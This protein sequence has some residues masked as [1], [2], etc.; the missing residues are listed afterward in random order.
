MMALYREK[1]LVEYAKRHG[2]TAEQL[3][4]R[5]LVAE[6]AALKAENAKLRE[7]LQDL[8]CSINGSGQLISHNAYVNARA[9][10]GEDR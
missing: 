3:A 2:I 6:N 10:L 1:E 9:A 8:F 4:G 5:D 7:L